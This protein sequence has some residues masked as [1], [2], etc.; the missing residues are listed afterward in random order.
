M[1]IIIFFKMSNF[2]S[3]P[4]ITLPDAQRSNIG[5]PSIEHQDSHPNLIGPMGSF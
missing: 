4:Q 2:T 3:Q 5:T 1:V